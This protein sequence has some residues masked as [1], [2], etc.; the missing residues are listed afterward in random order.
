MK[1][2][3]PVIDYPYID[4]LTNEALME[5]LVDYE[6][7]FYSDNPAKELESYQKLKFIID[8]HHRDY[9]PMPWWDAFRE[10]GDMLKREVLDR[11]VSGRARL[12]K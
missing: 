2:I 7:V 3:N 6:E 11:L 10:V 1:S 5:Q 8:R 9:G 4:A 12:V